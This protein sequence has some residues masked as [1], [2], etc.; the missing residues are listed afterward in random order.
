LAS[1]HLGELFG[2]R[3][4]AHPGREF[5]L[6]LEPGQRLAIDLQNVP[7]WLIATRAGDPAEKRASETS[8]R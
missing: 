8:A 4:R 3:A 5:H 2:D 1:L 6:G 7:E